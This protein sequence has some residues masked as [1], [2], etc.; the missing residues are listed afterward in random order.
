MLNKLL[1]Q[2]SLWPSSQNQPSKQH[3]RILNV[4]NSWY[5]CNTWIT[6]PPASAVYF[7]Q[8]WIFTL[9]IRTIYRTSI[10]SIII[11]SGL[12]FRQLTP[13][14]TDG[15]SDYHPGHERLPSHWTEHDSP[16]MDTTGHTR[17]EDW[18][19]VAVELQQ[20]ERQQERTEKFKKTN[21]I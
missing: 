16:T 2:P 9:H 15:R 14:P 10:N 17:P 3:M 21:T 11:L 13:I 20:Q 7:H 18:Q 12:I 1:K 19:E 4:W 6:V 5:M 8:Y